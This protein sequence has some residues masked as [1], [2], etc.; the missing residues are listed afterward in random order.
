MKVFHDIR[1]PLTCIDGYSQILLNASEDPSGQKKRDTLSRISFCSQQALGLLQDLMD[2][3]SIRRG[4]FR[5]NQ[6]HL[7]IENL[8]SQAVE[9]LEVL[10][11]SKEISLKLENLKGRT[12]VFVDAR[13]ILQV[14]SNLISNAVRHTPRGGSIKISSSLEGEIVKINVLDTG[15]G[16]APEE[17]KKI[18]RGFYRSRN[19]GMLGLG[20]SIC[21]DIVTQHGGKIGVTSEGPGK[22]S[23]F[24]FTLPLASFAIAYSLSSKKPIWDRAAGWA[25]TA[26]ILIS[27][28]VVRTHRKADSVSPNLTQPSSGSAI[29]MNS[30]K[31]HEPNLAPH[32]T[33]ST[34]PAL[35]WGEKVRREYLWEN[36][37]WERLWASRPAVASDLKDALNSRFSDF[38][39]SAMRA[40]LPFDGGTVLKGLPGGV[41]VP[42]SLNHPKESV[43]SRE[44]PARTLV[45][46]S[47]P[48]LYGHAQEENPASPTPLLWYGGSLAGVLVL[49]PFFFRRKPGRYTV[50]N[51]AP[52]PKVVEE[53]RGA[54]QMFRQRE[55]L[56]SKAPTIPSKEESIPDLTV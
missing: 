13:R 34:I 24:Y 5:L 55:S 31:A 56:P 32:E 38:E 16:I 54:T 39:S 25:I 49:A 42:I 53:E 47:P 1:N 50:Q 28:W 4:N 44:E 18:F 41:R 3:E 26:S 36:Q 51:L 12:L 52:Y 29:A 23:C 37:S 14:L 22:G 27:L 8:L 7:L 40:S 11:R 30:K 21:R 46:K 15:D 19:G 35:E 20:L 6:S 17:Q 48:P 10:S 45:V 33:R 2:H 9:G 43:T